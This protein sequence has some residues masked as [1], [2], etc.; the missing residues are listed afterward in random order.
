M[1]LLVLTVGYAFTSDNE[2]VE[3]KA[4]ESGNQNELMSC[5]NS[6]SILSDVEVEIETEIEVKKAPFFELTDSER[7]TVECM[8]MGEAGN[9]SF[10]GMC[11]VA[12][13]I[14]NA[15]QK[16][17]IL[18]SEVRNRYKYSG[19]SNSPSNDAILAVKTVFDDGDTVVDEPIMYFYNPKI[20]KSSWHESQCFVLEEGD[21]RFFKEW[22]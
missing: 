13:C 8:V 19:W 12:Q 5:I 10:E 16:D 1:L 18:P 2:V 6:G 11:L 3:A 15:S 22:D 20:C 4:L 21:H 17:G 7:K 9:Q 14:L